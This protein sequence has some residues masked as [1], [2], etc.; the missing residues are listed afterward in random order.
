M[1]L[2]TRNKLGALPTGVTS[3]QE[4]SIAG[5]TPSSETPADRSETNVPVQGA[6]DDLDDLLEK[7]QV[8]TSAIL[9]GAIASI[10]GFMFGY[11]SGQISGM[12][13]LRSLQS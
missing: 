2:F 9:L 4:K 12:Q 10:G 11:E 13:Y 5:S 8:T 6:P 7:R 1:R 3:V